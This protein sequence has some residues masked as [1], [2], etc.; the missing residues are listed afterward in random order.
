MGLMLVC[1]CLPGPAVRGE[2]KRKRRRTCKQ[3]SPG[4]MASVADGHNG[5]PAARE[6]VAHPRPG[7]CEAPDTLP[8]AGL[9]SGQASSLSAA[10]TNGVIRGRGP[11]QMRACMCAACDACTART[12]KQG[13]FAAPPP[14]SSLIPRRDYRCIIDSL[15]PGRDTRRCAGPLED[16][17]HCHA[18]R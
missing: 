10:G 5:S 14:P 9:G 4:W 13:C 12:G 6:W 11:C 7:R 1:P 16:L 18:M 8:G 15:V 3:Q 2:G 17:R